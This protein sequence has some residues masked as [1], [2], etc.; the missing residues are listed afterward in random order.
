MNKSFSCP[1]NSPARGRPKDASKRE[2]ILAAASSLFLNR[3]FHGTSMDALAEAAGVSKATVYSHFT[4][5]NALYQALIR[6]KVANYQLDDLSPYLGW[7]MRADLEMIGRNILDLIFDPEALAMLRM[8]I[9][10]GQQ[11]P[12]LSEMFRTAGPQVVFQQLADY[13]TEQKRRGV[14]YLGNPEADC[15]LHSGLLIEHRMMMQVLIGS[16]AIPNAEERQALAQASA[17]RFIAVKKSEAR[18]S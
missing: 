4:D 2:G 7:D 12:G 5:K 14:A 8:V 15:G 18:A 3:G 1:P 10:E 9:Y 6:N 17:R 13:F 11:V 16:Q